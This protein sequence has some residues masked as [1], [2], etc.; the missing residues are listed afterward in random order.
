MYRTILSASLAV[1]SCGAAFGQ[2][3]PSF[4]VASVKPA[5]APSTPGMLRVG[6]RGGPGTPDPGQITYSNVSLKN[7][8]MNAYNVKGYQ[9]TGPKWLDSERF[10]IVA[11]V[12]KGATKEEFRLMLQNLLAERFKLSLHHESKELPIYG[13]VVGKN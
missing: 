13:L 4:E 8:I 5:E 2:A 12:P 7:V 9:I 11:K 10:D 6:M 1:L 3:S